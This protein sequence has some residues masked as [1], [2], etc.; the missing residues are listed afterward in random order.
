MGSLSGATAQLPVVTVDG[1]AAMPG[2]STADA[3]KAG[4]FAAVLGGVERLVASV[5]PKALAVFFGGG[6][7]ERL[8]RRWARPAEHWPLMTLEG[9]RL[10][11][12]TRTHS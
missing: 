1:D 8:A 12:L 10:T 4:V 11:S 7:G 9:L 3:I 5:E 2:T 6:D